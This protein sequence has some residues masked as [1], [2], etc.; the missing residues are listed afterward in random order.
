M[1]GVMPLAFADVLSKGPESVAGSV[2]DVY[3][4]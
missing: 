4:L 3:N 1:H 2:D